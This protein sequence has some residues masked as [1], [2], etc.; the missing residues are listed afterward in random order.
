MSQS[1][2]VLYPPDLYSLTHRGNPGDV[3]YYLSACRGQTQ[4][5]ELGCGTGRLT[6]P[7]LREGHHITALDLHPGM[8]QTLEAQAKADDA[9][10]PSKL[11]LLEAD[12]C[13][14]S[15]AQP[16]ERILLPYN[17]MYCL[18]TQEDIIKCLKRVKEHLAPGG[19]CLFD[20]Y[21]VDEEALEGIEEDGWEPYAVMQEDEQTIEIHE[22][23]IWDRDTQRVDAT[24]MYCIKEGERWRKEEYTI[25]QIYLHPH[26]C[27]GCLEEAGLFPTQVYG[28]FRGEPLSEESEHLV[29]W[30][31]SM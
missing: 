1:S 10:D 18:L 25:P 6:L 21:L 27:L 29:V 13:S 4:L 20:I 7:L 24:Y 2:Q 12:M 30:A 23:R 31:K 15:L 5:L 16:F 14:F 17:V 28:G 3:S 11:E 22:R 9:I 26:Q 8:L 19:T